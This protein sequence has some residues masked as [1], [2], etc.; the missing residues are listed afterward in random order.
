[1]VSRVCPRRALGCQE[2]RPPELE[3]DPVVWVTCGQGGGQGPQRARVCLSS[4][5]QKCW[6]EQG[7]SGKPDPEQ[8][9]GH[10]SL[11]MMLGAHT[12]TYVSTHV[13]IQTRTHMHTRVHTHTHACVHTC[14]DLPRASRRRPQCQRQ[15]CPKTPL[16][17]CTP[18]GV[19]QCPVQPLSSPGGRGARVGAPPTPL[20]VATA[21]GDTRRP[22]AQEATSGSSRPLSSGVSQA[23]PE[24]QGRG[25]PCLRV[26]GSKTPPCWPPGRLTAA[27]G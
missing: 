14:Q 20:A 15:H 2:A 7:P 16:P 5:V 22:E 18:R 23:G 6:Q 4:C 19:T 11:V 1:M 24:G 17:V 9:G 25:W 8:G 12:Q 27:V 26:G 3:P 10:L 21:P 13:Y